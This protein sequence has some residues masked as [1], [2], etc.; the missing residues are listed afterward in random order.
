M[1]KIQGRLSA[2]DLWQ[3]FIRRLEAANDETVSEIEHQVRLQTLQAWRDGIQQAAGYTFNGDMH[4]AQSKDPVKRA[5]WD[6][7]PLCMGLI[8]DWGINNDVEELL[9]SIDK[10]GKSHD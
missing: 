1:K 3:E 9:L 5:I 6:H 7:R 8:L 4:Y 2:D 10:E